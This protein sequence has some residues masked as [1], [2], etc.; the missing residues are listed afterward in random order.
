MGFLSEIWM[1]S[2][3]IPSSREQ[4]FWVPRYGVYQQTRGLAIWEVDQRNVRHTSDG[5]F[6]EKQ[7][8]RHNS[9]GGLRAVCR[10]HRDRGKQRS[11]SKPTSRNPQQPAPDQYRVGLRAQADFS[12]PIF[13]PVHEARAGQRAALSVQSAAA[14]MQHLDRRSANELSP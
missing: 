7:H 9:I 3:L 8:L 14:A 10:R 5:P 4:H 11:R 1:I 13:E 6:R 12:A 2:I